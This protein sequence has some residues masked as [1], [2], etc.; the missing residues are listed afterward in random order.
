MSPPAAAPAAGLPTIQE[1]RQ[2]TI[3]KLGCR[4]CLWQCEVALAV[5]KGDRDIVCISATGSG[6]TL[7]FWMPLLFRPQGV[8][9]IITP[10]NLLGTQ[11]QLQLQNLGIAVA[12]ISGDTA[13]PANFQ[14]AGAMAH[15]VVILNPETAF[16]NKL[17]YQW[18]WRN[19]SFTSR[20]I[21]V[22]WDEAHCIATWGSFRPSLAESG[23]LRNL[24]SLKVPYLL[25]SATF[26]DP[27]CGQVLNIVQARKDRLL[28]LQRS[29][30][31]PNILLT[32]RKI[33]YP[34]VS[35][36]DLDFLIPDNCMAQTRIP[37]FVIF[38][39]SIEDSI[40]AAEALRKRLPRERSDKLVW[41]NSDN[42]PFFR[43]QTTEDFRASNIIGLC[44][45]D[46]FGMGMDV[47]NIEVVM[48][49][50]MTCDLNTLCQRFGRAA[51]GFGTQALAILF[52]EA[53]FFDDEKAAAAVR[54]QKRHEADAQKAARK[55]ATKRKRAETNTST[56]GAPLGDTVL[57]QKRT[58]L[59]AGASLAPDPSSST[60]SAQSSAASLSEYE[61]L[62]VLYAQAH[63]ERDG[64]EPNANCKGSKQ[65]KDKELAVLVEM[66]SIINAGL[67]PTMCYRKPITA[68]YENDRI[69]PDMHP[70]CERCAIRP[71]STSGPCCSLCSPNH[72]LLAILPP[73]DALPTKTS[74]PRASKVPAKYPMNSH[75]TELQLALNAFRRKKTLERFGQS[76]LRNRGASAIMPNEILQRIADC[77]HAHK[78]PS[79]DHL[80]RETKWHRASEFGEE[81]LQ[82]VTR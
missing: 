55:E 68:Y 29:N 21:S 65:K 75:D 24:L 9:M 14:A 4:P 33:R 71:P 7:T 51:R 34:L 25:P 23:R 15:G 76:H 27:L 81:V 32:V 50:K 22:V 78:L 69:G 80:S 63:R 72:P 47:S 13:C 1:I 57:G 77:A 49:W 46:S 3:E 38:F 52:V 66:D 58:R 37:S 17:S 35:Y 28:R 5:L 62:R 10:L 2:R 79:V 56:V 43:T 36:R 39:D 82:I 73:L 74:A 19:S 59:E 6:K 26:P 44:S 53:K 64:A 42:T 20:L 18:L 8:Q 48:Q 16:K 61:S 70:C 45:T 54:S 40:A 67:R 31:R 12:V 41:F 30:D 11:N 60:P